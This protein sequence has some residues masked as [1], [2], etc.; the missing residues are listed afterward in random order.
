[1]PPLTSLEQQNGNLS[2]QNEVVD[3]TGQANGV[4]GS[5]VRRYT[6][7]TPPIPP[8]T[9]QTYVGADGKT[10]AAA[11]EGTVTQVP[12]AGAAPSTT[13][14]GSIQSAADFDANRTGGVD[15]NS[16]RENVRQAN[17]STIDAIN[18]NYTNLIASQAKT[19]ENNTGQTRAVN[20]RSGLLGSDFGK[21]N[22]DNQETANNKAIQALTDEQNQKIAEVNGQIDS[23][24]RAEIAA[25]K[26]EALGNADAYAKYLSDAQTKAS[27]SLK[28]LGESGTTV[29]TLRSQSPDT[30]AYLEKA[31]GMTDFQLQ[32]ELSSAAGDKLKTDTKIVGDTAYASVY[33]PT[34][35]KFETHVQ[36]FDVPDGSLVDF[37]NGNIM[38]KSVDANGKVTYTDATPAKPTEVSPG[39]SLVDSTGKVLYKAPYS[40]SQLNAGGTGGGGGP[41][42]VPGANPTVD[43][44][45][46]NVNTGKAKLS[47]VPNNLLNAVATG[48]AATGGNATGDLLNITQTALQGLQD[49]VS[50]NQGF[51]GAV[52]AKGLSSFFGLKGSPVAGTAAAD[53]DANLKQ[54]VNDV[55]LPN[56]TILHGLGR[57][58]DREFQSLQASITSL[59][60]TLSESEFKKQLANVT[61]IVNDKLTQSS[62]SGLSS[63]LKTGEILVKDGQG[64]IGAIPASEFDPKL[65]TKV[66][67]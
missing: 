54:V 5:V 10:Y 55:V 53:F 27:A 31:L 17:Q 43:S 46:Q 28:T 2:L 25:K 23:T 11:V 7:P 8:S 60:P 52:G 49:K 48:I 67:Q 24:A 34:T 57:V 56:L 16:I 14:A 26:Q 38:V 37:G 15:E 30:L 61:Q 44:W 33:N 65:Y 47:D 21:A 18:A 45:V 51:T 62:A 35:Q 6:A 9:G 66:Q 41:S 22:A 50:K 64:N 32:Q 4:G 13:G 19:N 42:Y 58:T 63:Q 59:S 29:E 36:K 1:M 12:A 40:P 39:G 3:P 20:S